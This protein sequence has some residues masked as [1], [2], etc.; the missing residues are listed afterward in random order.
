MHAITEAGVLEALRTVH[1][2]EAPVNIVDLGL[3]E[4]VSVTDTAIEVELVPTYR[5]CPA[6]LFLARAAENAIAQGAPDAEINVRWSTATTWTAERLSAEGRT[7]LREFGIAVADNAREVHCP[8]CGNSEVRLDN[9]FGCA[10]CKSLY[11][12]PQCRNP[13][14]VM[15][16]TMVMTSPTTRSRLID[17]KSVV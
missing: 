6:K 10:V 1:D 7:R 12:C 15:R 5:S 14:E 13:F 3:L 11:Y 16:G 8:H 2:P 4:S 9:Q 17:R